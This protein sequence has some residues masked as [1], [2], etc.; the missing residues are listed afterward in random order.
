MID[1]KWPRFLGQVEAYFLK[2][3]F[4]MQSSFYPLSF[5][6]WFSV[7]SNRNLL[8]PVGQGGNNN[9]NTQNDTIHLS[10]WQLSQ[11]PPCMMFPCLLL[12]L[13]QSWPLLYAHHVPRT[14]QRMLYILIFNFIMLISHS[15]QNSFMKQEILLCPFKNIFRKPKISL[16]PPANLCWNLNLSSVKIPSSHS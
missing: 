2:L 4:H 10:D 12:L 11:L 1:L 7:L 5:P 9:V 15:S 6:I 14:G 8:F 16:K 13:Q 3:V